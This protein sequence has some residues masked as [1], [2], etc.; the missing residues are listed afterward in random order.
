[1]RP[2]AA[3]KTMKAA[4]INELQTDTTV[5]MRLEKAQVNTWLADQ[6]KTKKTRGR[7]QMRSSQPNPMEERRGMKRDLHKTKQGELQEAA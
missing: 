5:P 6:H 3:W 1:M 4:F 7:K 2:K